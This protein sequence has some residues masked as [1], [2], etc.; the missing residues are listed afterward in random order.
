MVK[1][2]D[3]STGNEWL[4]EALE[5]YLM[6]GLEPGGFLT[7]VLC[8]NLFAA[9][10]AADFMNREHI[11]EIV[12]AIS[13]NMPCNSYGSKQAFALWIQDQDNR[14]SNYAARLEKLYTFRVLKGST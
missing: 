6:H 13:D 1:Y 10:G 8:N 12:K 5:N 11:S 3:F 7:A 2:I 9:V 14:R 4:D